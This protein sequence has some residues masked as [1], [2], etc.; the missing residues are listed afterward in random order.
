MKDIQI[1]TIND[2]TSF[3]V[4]RQIK[5]CK[6]ALINLPILWGRGTPESSVRAKLGTL[7]LNISGGA[8]T[9]LYVKETEQTTDDAVG[10]V[11][12]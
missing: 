10:W 2:L 12:K 5:D 1:R 3:E 7:Y 8:S 9:T 11:A 4:D 6:N